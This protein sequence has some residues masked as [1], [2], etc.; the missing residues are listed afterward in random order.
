MLKNNL[1]I[2]LGAM[3]CCSSCSNQGYSVLASTGTV[4]G[5]EV[6]ENPA[7]QF[8]QA[9]LGYNRA[10]LAFVPSNRNGEK[11]PA[12]SFGSGAKDVADVLMEL[13]YGGIFDTGPSSGIYQRLA[14]GEKAVHQPG[15]SVMFAKN[16]DGSMET[17]AALALAAANPQELANIQRKAVTSLTGQMSS[18]DKVD[19]NKL[20]ELFRC[21]GFNETEVGKSVDKY[22]GMTQ[23]EFEI[24]FTKDFGVIA[25]AFEQKLNDCKN[26]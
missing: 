6:S 24:E 13:R 22:K 12:G 16:A 26:K 18:N 2:M 9:K 10:E 20:A 3:V 7:T 25:P 17:E 23:S 4:I 8:P 19:A 15:A 1:L 5:V 21:V 14:V 11:N